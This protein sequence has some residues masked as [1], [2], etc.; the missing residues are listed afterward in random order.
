MRLLEVTAK[1]ILSRYGIEPPPGREC[2][3]VDEIRSA[4]V[5][6]GPEV[7]LKAQI[8]IGDRATQGLVRSV[9]D[10]DE[11]VAIGGAYLGRAVDGMS[12]ESTLVE[13]AIPPDESLYVSIH[14]EDAERARVLYLGWGGGQGYQRDAA[15][16]QAALPV[17]A[18]DLDA[19]RILVDGLG[20][21][22]A[23]REALAHVVLGLSSA[24]REWHAY[25]VEI[26]PLFL[27]GDAAV[28]IDAKME[29]DD[30]S[31]ATVP[32][33]GLLPPQV[34]SPREVEARTY[35][36]SDHRGS[37][38]YVQLIE[39]DGVTGPTVVGSHSV[40]GGESLVVFDALESVGLQPANYC[41]TSGAPPKEKMAFAAR[42][43]ASQPHIAGYFF[44]TC[45][46]NQ[47]LSITANGLVEG[48]E[49]SGWRGPTVCRIAGNQEA[50]ARE[51]VQ[52]WATANDVPSLIVGREYDEWQ[53]AAALADL[54]E[55]V[56]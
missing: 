23:R 55:R 10:P 22:G 31:L 25:T 54:L 42:L 26:N 13:A 44:S 43:I 52:A 17:D 48:F 28:A 8:A 33:P 4:A 34:E 35:Q 40:G 39:P 50:E 29:L 3:S 53:A 19:A 37:F 2:R 36:Q 27:V 20:V 9:G 21:D 51:I 1:E 41:D 24:A 15:E 32:E 18:I 30:Y 45:I 16:V 38:R 6:L 47:P 11:A 7:Y 56:A 46:A 12:I 49:A 14:V 5:E